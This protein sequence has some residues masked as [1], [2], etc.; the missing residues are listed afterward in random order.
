MMNADINFNNSDIVH[1]DPLQTSEENLVETQVVSVQPFTELD[2]TR[3]QW[4][5]LKRKSYNIDKSRKLIC[6]IR[7]YQS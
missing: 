5:D 4:I 3:Q 7:E 2:R 6:N 1:N